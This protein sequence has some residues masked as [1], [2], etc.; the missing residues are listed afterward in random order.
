MK[1]SNSARW[2]LAALVA[3]IALIVALWP[4]AGGSGDADG[5][6]IASSR[7]SSTNPSAQA[8]P[9]EPVAGLSDCPRSENADAALTAA[10]PLVGITLECLGSGAVIDLAQSLAGTPAL[11]NLWAYWCGP[12]AT[13]LPI[14]QEFAAEADKS[15]NVVTV[16]S[17]PGREQAVSR[18]RDLNVT[19]PAVLDGSARVRAAVGAPAVLPVTVLV[20][21]DGTIAKVVAKPFDSVEEIRA[22][23][24]ENLGVAL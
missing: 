2:S 23:V 22:T 15:I 11:L 6:D 13:E 9:G 24:A 17:D 20:R 10:G 19:L 18:L 1:L 21:A 12:C 8:L 14:L 7:A 16:H 3:V 5:S 4:R